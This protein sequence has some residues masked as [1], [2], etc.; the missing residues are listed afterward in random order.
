M[1]L[2]FNRMSMDKILNQLRFNAIDVF[3]ELKIKAA[4]P[5]KS[6]ETNNY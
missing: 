5:V 1:N 2:Q 6:G 3:E 4:T